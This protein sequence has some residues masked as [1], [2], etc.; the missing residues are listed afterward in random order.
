VRMVFSKDGTR[1]TA[2]AALAVVA[3]GWVADTAG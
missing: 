2:E 1:D 3:V